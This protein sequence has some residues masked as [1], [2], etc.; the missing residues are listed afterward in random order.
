MNQGPNHYGHCVY[1]LNFHLVLVTEY[2]RAA[3]T[4]AMLDRL[5][6]IFSERCDGWRG[7]LLEFN[8]EA[9]HVNALLD[10]PPTVEISRFVNNIKTVSS[11]LL[12]RDFAPHLKRYYG[13]PVL[14]SRSY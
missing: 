12:R 6:E 14:W 10:L 5:R 4:G 13:K 8:G 3:L 9:D 11:R 1:K 7:R 2:R